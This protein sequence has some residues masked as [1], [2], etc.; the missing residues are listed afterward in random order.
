MQQCNA[1]RVGGA[2]DQQEIIRECADSLGGQLGVLVM[3]NA[4][5]Q[6]AVLEEFINDRDALSVA[7][8]KKN[9]D[10][11]ERSVHESWREM[12]VKTGL[13][14]CSRRIVH[15]LLKKER[16]RAGINTRVRLPSTT[17]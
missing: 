3:L 4:A 15:E 9:I 11:V 1:F 2:V 5:E 6:P 8:N 14:Q 17:M 7:V 12:L 10:K 16:T 13:M